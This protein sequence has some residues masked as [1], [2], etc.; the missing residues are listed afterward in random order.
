MGIIEKMGIPGHIKI[1]IREMRPRNFPDIADQ[2]KGITSSPEAKKGRTATYLRIF[3]E[4][5]VNVSGPRELDPQSQ[6]FMP[7]ARPPI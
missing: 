3:A 2:K 4:E 1:I 7:P 5:G 6:C